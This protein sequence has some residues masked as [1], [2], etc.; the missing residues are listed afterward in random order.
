V[1]SWHDRQP[2]TG[3]LQAVTRLLQAVAGSPPAVAG[4]A[5]LLLACSPPQLSASL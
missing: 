2:V 5:L 1:I 3:L 4:A